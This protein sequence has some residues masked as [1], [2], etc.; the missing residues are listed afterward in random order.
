MI[1]R[2]HI[3]AFQS[4]IESNREVRDRL[5]LLKQDALVKDV[6]AIVTKIDT[7]YVMKMKIHLH[8]S[9]YISATSNLIKQLSKLCDGIEKWEKAVESNAGKGITAFLDEA[10]PITDEIGTALLAAEKKR[11]EQIENKTHVF[12]SLDEHYALRKHILEINS[13]VK[14]LSDQKIK[15]SEIF[16]KYFESLS[17]PE[18]L[19]IANG[20]IDSLEKMEKT[21]HVKRLIDIM[22]ELIKNYRAKI[23][24]M[25]KAFDNL[26][27][28][29]EAEADEQQ[30][31]LV[32]FSAEAKA[33]RTEGQS[34]LAAFPP[35]P[36]MSPI[37][38][39]SIIVPSFIIPAASDLPLGSE[40]RRSSVSSDSDELK[41]GSPTGSPESPVPKLSSSAIV[42][43][44]LPLDLSASPSSASELDLKSSQTPVYKSLPIVVGEPLSSNKEL[45][46][47]SSVAIS[48]TS[49]AP[50]EKEKSL[51][52]TLGFNRDKS[53]PL[54]P[55]AGSVRVT[56]AVIPQR[57]GLSSVS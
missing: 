51:L 45:K 52:A 12:P 36:K 27:E 44:M 7:M 8:A 10:E 32:K 35:I 37:I 57:N 56:L 33:I 53:V 26:A 1:P 16:L 39:A 46:Q 20:Y 29:E 4:Q 42:S 50:V 21:K 9:T 28:I 47:R 48:K 55:V 3:E 31:A 25:F 41:K 54:A 34:S 5:A 38:P 22:D 24:D 6:H 18:T 15:G 40:S 23:D 19:E 11:K 14:N 13:L 17:L 43:S 2:E 30:A 49:S